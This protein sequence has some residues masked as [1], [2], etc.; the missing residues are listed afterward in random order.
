MTLIGSDGSVNAPTP[1]N[2]TLTLIGLSSVLAITR[3]LWKTLSFRPMLS[4]APTMKVSALSV[5]PARTKDGS[6]EPRRRLAPNGIGSPLP[7]TG[8][9]ITR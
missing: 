3:S 2:V 8:L 9:T 7:S 4:R 1:V 6:F 5:R